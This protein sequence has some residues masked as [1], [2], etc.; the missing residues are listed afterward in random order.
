MC[1]G[2][3]HLSQ[4]GFNTQYPVQCRQISCSTIW[5]VKI[6]HRYVVTRPMQ[7]RYGYQVSEQ[8]IYIYIFFFWWGN[9]TEIMIKFC[10]NLGFVV[11]Y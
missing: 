11:I 4:V 7:S 2:L 5:F 9:I 3:N 6:L 8:F 1:Q 10:N